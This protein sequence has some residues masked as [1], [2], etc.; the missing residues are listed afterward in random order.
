MVNV[1]KK[2]EEIVVKFR[3]LSL[4]FSNK[5]MVTGL[6]NF[7]ETMNHLLTKMILS[8]TSN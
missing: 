3:S 4:R 8:K 7:E 2:K 1:F 6:L 5:I